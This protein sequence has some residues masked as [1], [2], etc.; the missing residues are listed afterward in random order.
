VGAALI[1]FATP[2]TVERK[3][4]MVATGL[5]FASTETHASR[6]DSE[7]EYSQMV[8]LSTLSWGTKLTSSNKC[9][10]SRC[11]VTE[12]E[13]SNREQAAGP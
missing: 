6:G 1:V 13:G 2:L 9:R 12:K 8:R 10:S 4:V 11:C 5:P 3:G 7:T